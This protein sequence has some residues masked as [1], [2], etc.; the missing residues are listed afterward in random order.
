MPSFL[1]K[2]PESPCTTSELLD[3]ISSIEHQQ[4]G[5]FKSLIG[6]IARSSYSITC[7]GDNVFDMFVSIADQWITMKRKKFIGFHGDGERIWHFDDD[8]FS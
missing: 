6:G 8:Y 2:K 3:Y 1:S 5:V 7:I 4:V